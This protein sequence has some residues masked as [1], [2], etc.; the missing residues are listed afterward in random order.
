MG[1]KHFLDGGDDFLKS[2]LGKT[3]KNSDTFKYFL[4]MKGR[5]YEIMDRLECKVINVKYRGTQLT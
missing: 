5:G 1:S 4:R 2:W 3:H